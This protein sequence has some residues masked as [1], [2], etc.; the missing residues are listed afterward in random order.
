MELLGLNP[1]EE[2]SAKNLLVKYQEVFVRDEGDLG[3][4]SLIEHQIPLSDD[5]PV[6]QHYRRISPSQYEAV[7][8]HIKQLLGSQ[9]IR[10]SC[11]PYSSPIVLVQKKD[12]TL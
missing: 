6:W 11:S 2:Q 5:I 12:G 1:Q 8:S 7:K 3:C 4:T 9:V 10:E